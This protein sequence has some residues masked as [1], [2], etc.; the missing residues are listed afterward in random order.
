VHG[1]GVSLENL[2]EDEVLALRYDEPATGDELA[3]WCGGGLLGQ[4]ITV[5]TSAGP[6]P[7]EVGDWIVRD[8]TGVF[9]VH[10]HEDFVLH[11]CA[12]EAWVSGSR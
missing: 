12:P 1:D 11:Y 9:T 3:L 7:A 8:A 10:A 2:D 6:A 4:T 5:P